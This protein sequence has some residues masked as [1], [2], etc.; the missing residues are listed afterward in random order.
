M[1]FRN[2]IWLLGICAGLFAC[3]NNGKKKQP[4]ADSTTDSVVNYP[5]TGMETEPLLR[6]A[7]SLQILYYDNPDGD[8]IRYTRFYHYTATKDTG[9]IKGLIDN[10]NLPV[11]KQTT[12]K[13]CRSEGKIYVFGKTEEPLKTIYFS[14][15]C[16]T[17]CYLYFIKEGA[18][19]YSPL[20]ENF[21]DQLRKN[22]LVSKTP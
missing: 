5:K 4:V 19:F 20:S 14:T 3:N 12:I 8:S 7:D 22:K 16:D 11:E 15:R 13:K 9:T 2:V 10:L 18:F 17:C 1:N 21:K 6:Q